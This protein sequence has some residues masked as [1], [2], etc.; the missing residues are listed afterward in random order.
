MPQ[1]TEP[2]RSYNIIKYQTNEILQITDYLNVSSQ[3][4]SIH[5]TEIQTETKPERNYSTQKLNATNSIENLRV[6]SHL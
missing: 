1:K 5:W 2:Q 3:L 4:N 6:P